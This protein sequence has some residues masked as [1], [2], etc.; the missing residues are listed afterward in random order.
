M[1]RF[2]MLTFCAVACGFSVSAN[3][4]DRSLQQGRSLELQGQGKE[5]RQLWDAGIA[6]RNSRDAALNLKL[7][8]SYALESDWIAAAAYAELSFKSQRPKKP[9][10]WLNI[11]N[12]F[13]LGGK[14]EQ[15]DALIVAYAAQKNLADLD[16][17][18]TRLNM[19]GPNVF[20]DQQAL[21]RIADKVAKNRRKNAW[22][23]VVQGA[24]NFR[25][26]NYQRAEQQL[27]TFARSTASDGWVDAL[28]HYWM[29]MTL[30]KLNKKED[31]REWLR[32]GEA[33]SRSNPSRPPW[34][35]DYKF[36]PELE[37]LRREAFQQVTGEHP[38]ELPSLHKNRAPRRTSV[39]KP[40]VL[41]S[42]LPTGLSK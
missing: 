42:S 18:K 41:R 9:A 25:A 35:N 32:K 37:L 15:F 30:M 10:D 1:K 11:A 8:R 24:T 12:L 28:R 6:A 17:I 23:L 5:A 40:G 31:A 16:H 38:P 4:Q 7:A 3:A 34:V 22:Y 33:L 21:V 19:L 2:L 36:I 14:Q 27:T 29:A 13:E 20:E 39:T 26:K